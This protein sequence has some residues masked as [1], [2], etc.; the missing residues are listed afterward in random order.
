MRQHGVDVA[1]PRLNVRGGRYSVRM[2]HFTVVRSLVRV[3]LAQGDETV[4]HQ[5]E[6]LAQALNKANDKDAPTISKMLQSDGGS[7]ALAP[8][9]LAKS[10]VEA[11]RMKPGIRVPVDRETSAPLATIVF[12]DEN[13]A[14]R[15]VFPAHTSAS[16]DGLWLEW[17]HHERLV[18]AGMR[19]ALSCL[20]YG[21]P[22]TGK[23]SL[24]MWLAHELNL[25]AVVARLD[26]LISSY[27][28]TTAR[29]MGAL[30]DFANRYECVLILDEFDAI[31][32]LR[33][34]P[35]EVGEIKRV[36]NTLLQNIDTRTNRGITIGITNHH[37]LLDPAVWRRFEVQLSTPLPAEEQ[38]MHVARSLLPDQP[39]EAKFIAWISDGYSGSELITLIDR[40]RKRSLLSEDSLPPAE[41]ICHLAASTGG[42]TSPSYRRVGI[43]EAHLMHAL[44]TSTDIRFQQAE[45]ATLTGVSTK[46]VS[47]RV[48]DII[49]GGNDGE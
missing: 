9:R 15:P 5:V 4:R 6:R 26:G 1:L 10:S 27:L 22:G 11:E 24:A 34:D 29:N 16:V 30:F 33:D 17:H 19:P 12:P 18:Q 13:T 45:I 49:E 31:A 40:Y 39:L 7:K 38:R 23:T 48:S 47:R 43:D 41:V 36:V 8:S 46:T 21:P 14:T 44:S 25:P 3:A 35:N 28:G 2:E 32:K 42:A 20:I 37:S